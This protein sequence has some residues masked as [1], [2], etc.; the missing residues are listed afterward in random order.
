MRRSHVVSALFLTAALAA[1]Q[2]AGDPPSRVARLNHISG[3][4]SFR[5]D[6][7][8]E[9]SEATLNYPLYN[10]DHLWAAAGAQTEMHLDST[11]IRMGTETALGIVN[12][13][14]RGV[15]LSL[16][17][18]T[19]QVHVRNLDRDESF[20]ID[21]PNAAVT[22]LRAGDYRI[23]V[24]ENNITEVTVRAGDAEVTGGGRAFPVRARYTARIT[25]IDDSLASDL[26]P[27]PSPDNF[28]RWCQ[29]RDMRDEQ[30]QSVRYVSRETIGY[31]DLDENGTWRE[32]PEYGWVWAPRVAVGWAPYRYG[33]WAWI[34]P[35]GWTWVDNA[36]WG[37]APFHYGRW[38]NAGGGWVWVPGAVAARPVYAP[39]LVVFAAGPRLTWFPL[40]PREVY[41]PSYR[42][43]DRYVRQVNVTHV[44]VTNINVTNANV[45][46]M[47]EGRVFNTTASGQ[48]YGANRP[49]RAVVF[50][51]PAQAAP[52]VRVMERAVVTRRPLP[53]NRPVIRET[54]PRQIDRPVDRPVDRSTAKPRSGCACVASGQGDAPGEALVIAIGLL[55]MRRSGRRRLARASRA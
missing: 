55:V 35:W 27:A 48:T 12:L 19:L 4:V 25:G 29:A 8:Q 31:E 46:Y 9:W 36:S 54:A 30:S 32:M 5:P 41:R 37:F 14:D 22:L 28:D 44:N 47:H 45:R 43:S 11:A 52:P 50:G 20:E 23:S 6:D 2:D 49:E 53:E 13:D 16:T 24:D 7:V 26:T 1:A 34:S 40:G 42:V 39:A 15:Q 51:R 38:A 17:G 3:Q 18:G 21:T 33:H 10:G